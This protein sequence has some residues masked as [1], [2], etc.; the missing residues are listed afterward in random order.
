MT[1]HAHQDDYYVFL[2]EI[3]DS[4]DVPTELPAGHYYLFKAEKPGYATVRKVLEIQKQS[5]ELILH[6]ALKIGKRAI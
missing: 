2:I 4:V 3:P 1:I 5:E 6:F